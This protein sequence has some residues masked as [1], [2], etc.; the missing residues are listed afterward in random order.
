MNTE[1]LNSIK[2]VAQDLT[3]LVNE[4]DQEIDDRSVNQCSAVLKRLLV[5]NQYGKAWNV[6]GINRQPKIRTYN[7][8]E[9]ML[10]GESVDTITLAIAG[11]AKYRGSVIR[12]FRVLNYAKEKERS[13]DDQKKLPVNLAMSLSQYL[14]SVC[15]IIDGASVTRGELISYLADKCTCEPVD[16]ELTAPTSPDSKLRKL[17]LFFNSLTTGDKCGLY[18]ELV[19]T[20]QCI[21]GTRDTAKL[22][23]RIKELQVQ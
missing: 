12:G 20:G 19:C 8:E 9:L 23:K 22:L 1:E 11:G 14:N 18:Y 21:A 5:E 10:D 6:L 3:Y 16:T 7:F 4:W 13:S 2:S 17:D 15:I